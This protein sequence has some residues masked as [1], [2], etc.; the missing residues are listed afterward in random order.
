MLSFCFTLPI[1]TGPPGTS[2]E[3]RET[4]YN[5]DKSLREAV[6]NEVLI[7][8]LPD[9]KVTGGTN[10]S[11][12]NA[13]S[14]FLSI[15]KLSSAYWVEIERLFND[16]RSVASRM[17]F[18]LHFHFFL[19]FINC[20]IRRR[21]DK[22]PGGVAGATQNKLRDLMTAVSLEVMTVVLAVLFL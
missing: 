3:D 17:F 8:R 19:S 4:L 14:P 11:K 12:M 5:K 9:Y 1:V 20:S 21:E 15:A 13:I 6:A 16:I 22:T 10:K 7:T 2:D 18:V